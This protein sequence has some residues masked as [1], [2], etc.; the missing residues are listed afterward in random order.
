MIDASEVITTVKNKLSSNPASEATFVLISSATILS[1][2]RG[3]LGDT[4]EDYRW[5]DAVLNSF[6]TMGIADIKQKRTDAMYDWDGVILAAAS[7]R[8]SFTTALY[9]FTLSRAYDQ[10]AGLNDNNLGLSKTYEKNYYDSLGTVLYFYPETIL[11]D[12]IN[13]GIQAVLRDRPDA[14]LTE[15]GLWRDPSIIVVVADQID[16]PEIF[17]NA[18]INFTAYEAI[19]AMRGDAK[20]AQNFFHFIKARYLANGTLFRFICLH[21]AVCYWRNKSSR[22]TVGKTCRP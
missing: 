8:N 3:A 7:I 21:S 9:F 1:D 5:S 15:T 16:L 22:Y 13:N 2:V 20:S 10:D 19:L 17:R 14:S 4:I 6:I 12:A 11:T 18:I